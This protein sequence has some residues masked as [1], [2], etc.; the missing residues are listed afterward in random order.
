MNFNISKMV[1]YNII[2]S[3][4]NDDG[5]GNEDGKEAIGLD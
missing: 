5:D 2:G 3:L 4:I 1:Y